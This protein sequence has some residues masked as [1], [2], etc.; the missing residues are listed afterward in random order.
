MPTIS[1]FHGVL[2]ASE[3]AG[4]FAALREPSRFAAVCIQHGA[5]SWPGD[6]DLAPD[7]MQAAIRENGRFVM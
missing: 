4:V 2:L 5:V 7:A 6:M 3:A 1:Q